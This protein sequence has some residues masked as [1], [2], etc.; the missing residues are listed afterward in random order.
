MFWP[1]QNRYLSGGY[2]QAQGLYRPDFEH[3]ACGVGMVASIH[4]TKSNQI[5]QTALE[6]VCN[7]MH[8]GALDADA[9]SGDGAG[10]LTQI[11]HRFFRREIEKLG[12]KLYRDEDL[13]VGMFFLPASNVYAQAR[14]RQIAEEVLTQRGLVVIGWRPVP[15]NIKVVGDKAAATAPKIEQCLIARPDAKLIDNELFERLLFL[16]RNAIEDRAAADKIADFYIPSMSSRTIVYKGMLTGPQLERFYLDLQDPAYETAIAIFHQRYSTNTFPTWGL[17]HPFR[18][19]AH[20]GEINTIRGNRNWVRARESELRHDFWG[21]DID[22]L[23]PII[24]DGGSDSAS[25][26]NALE[27]LAMSGRSLLHSMLMLVPAAYR[28]ETDLDPAIR[29]FYE[30]HGCLNEPWDGPAALAFSD[31]TIAAACLD[32]NGLRPARYKITKDGLFLL[33]SETGVVVIP[34]KD[35]V[36]KGRLAPGEMIAV[37]TTSKKLLRNHEIKKLVASQQPYEEWIKTHL[38][39]ISNYTGGQAVPALPAPGTDASFQ[40]RL[41]SFGY[42]EEE[43]K[44]ILVPMAQ[45][46]EEAIGSM[47]DDAPLAVFSRRPRLLYHYFRQLFAQVTNPPID[48]IREKLVMSTNVYCGF[49]P[50]WLSETP[51]HAK[52]LR[53]PSPVL[54]DA[55]LAAIRSIPDKHLAHAT[56]SVLFDAAGGTDAFAAALKRACSEAEQ[57]VDAGKSLVILSDK[58]STREQAALP[59]LLAVGAVHHHL[60]RVGKRM[61]AS[62]L[63]ETAE[64]RDVHHFACLI[65]YGASAVNP[66]AVYEIFADLRA[67]GDLAGLDDATV[68]ANYRAS[69]DKGLLK[70]MSKMGISLLSSYHGGQIFEAV[71]VG[72]DLI[73]TA[74]AGTPSLI[75]GIGLRELAEETVKR[76]VS[77]YETVKPA[78]AGFYRYRRDGEAHAITPPVI[79]SL[80]TY[81]GLKGGDKAARIEDYKKFVESVYASNPIT[82]RHMLRLKPGTPIPIEEVEPVEDIRKRFTTAGMSLG[83]LSPEAHEALAIAMNRIGG[84]SNSGEG[85]EDRSRFTPMENGDSK[86]SKIKQVASGRFGVTAE[87]LASA[88]EIE[89]KIA[90]GAKPGEG[91]QLPGHKV[92][93]MIAKLRHSTPGVMLISPPPHHDIYSIEDL[94]QLI[95]DLKQVNPRAKV[96]VKLVAEAGVGTIAAGVAKAHADI[97]LVSGHDGG[98]GA[99]PLSSIKYAGTPWELGVAETQQ[100][101]LLNG[102]RDRVTLR[103]DGGM[104]SGLDIIVAALLG[105]EEYNFGTTALIALGCVYVRQCHLNNC[106]TGVATQDDKFRAKYR[107]TPDA[108]VNYFNAVAQEVRELL[109]SIGARSLNDIIGHPEYLEQV[110]ITDHPKANTVDLKGLLTVPEIDDLTPRFHT[111][112]RNDKHE[113]QPLDRTILQDVKSTLQTRKKI[114]L[115]YKVKNVHRSVGTQLS[116]EIAYRYGDEG[117]PD[118]TINIRLEGSAGQSLGAFLVQGVNL[119]LVGEANDYVGKGMGGGQIVLTPPKGVP[120]NPSTNM[121]CGNTVLYGATGGRLFVHGCAGERFAVRNSGATAVVEGIG[122]H[123]CE[124]MTK[125]TVVVLGPTGKNFGAGMSGGIAY[126]LDTENRFEKTYNPAMVSLSRLEGEADAKELKGLI[127]NHLEATESAL[128]KS[129]LADWERFGPLFWKVVPHPPT[130]AAA[131]AAPAQHAQ[132]AVKH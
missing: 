100:V 84:K 17:A 24:Q 105:A 107:G 67:K 3:D 114:Q 106:P 51:D 115:S 37:D 31:G 88:A 10:V 12:H 4:G 1:M 8:R 59:M 116:G 55:D 18:M 49:K 57:A 25:L 90:Q 6:S 97:I 108:V 28:S 117:L 79:Q 129:I 83:A 102:L 9:K 15:V 69:I 87:Y 81:V 34:D 75:A 27:I 98:T 76:H 48:P 43:I 14:C 85:G 26:D 128:A 64:A 130:P 16:S 118:G 5:L 39:E 23:K 63:C 62:I 46:G 123:G 30:Y 13:G 50:N 32:R 103:T 74:F 93:A 73:E 132:T 20:N 78:D 21:S 68:L 52:L 72:P 33:S 40:A 111:W 66:Y 104:K 56:V 35:V 110:T 112:E 65:G 77:G 94:A 44:I 124:Y 120:F 80:H 119:T 19:L 109:A 99:S 2:P 61:R 7:L 121:V 41:Q 131:P 36:E 60:I 45:K 86:N 95:Y 58:G 92:S 113:D 42:N 91:G 127:F 126:V 125:G 22:K 54:T 71:G 38:R 82:I 11:P 70:I 29:A 122:D 89:I 47:G 96:C 101:L 53:L